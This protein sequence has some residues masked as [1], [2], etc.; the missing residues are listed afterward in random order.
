MDKESNL[1][2]FLN[3][4][5]RR[6]KRYDIIMLVFLKGDN[7]EKTVVHYNMYTNGVLLCRL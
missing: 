6:A 4:L 7:N 2:K 3:M 5:L 1:H